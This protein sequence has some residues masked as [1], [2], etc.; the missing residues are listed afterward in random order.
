MLFRQA[1]LC[2]H[3]R[4][5]GTNKVRLFGGR[6]RRQQAV[7]FY[8]FCISTRRLDSK[9]G[10]PHHF[11]WGFGT[12]PRGP[13]VTLFHSRAA[14]PYM[15]RRDDLKMLRVKSTLVPQSIL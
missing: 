10:R 2:T 7:V 14:E 11:L 1:T 5:A 13:H 6:P 8:L 4:N 3:Y 15:S 9:R 12:L